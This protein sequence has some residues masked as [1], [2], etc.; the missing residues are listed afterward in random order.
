MH[1]EKYK[2][3]CLF[4]DNISDDTNLNEVIKVRN[5]NGSREN[6]TLFAEKTI[7]TLKNCEKDLR[8]VTDKRGAACWIPYALRG[9]QCKDRS[10]DTMIALWIQKHC[11]HKKVVSHQ[12]NVFVETQKLYERLFLWLSFYIHVPTHT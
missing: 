7:L 1:K 12:S 10:L 8:S 5:F 2:M 6:I 9:R 3:W 4:M 11:T